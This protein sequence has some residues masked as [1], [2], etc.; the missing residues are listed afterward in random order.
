MSERKRKWDGFCPAGKHGL[1]YRGQPCDLCPAPAMPS[2]RPR[3]L[4]PHEVVIAA[5]YRACPF[6][7][8][9]DVGCRRCRICDAAALVAQ[10][11]SPPPGSRE[12]GAGRCPECQGDAADLWT[13]PEDCT[14]C[15]GRASPRCRACVHEVD[16][17][18]ER[19]A[20]EYHEPGDPECRLHAQ[21]APKTTQAPNVAAPT[22]EE[23]MATHLWFNGYDHAAGET[24]EDARRWMMQETRMSAEDCEGDGWRMVPDDEM[25]CDEAGVV[26][27]PHETAREFAESMLAAHPLRSR[28]AE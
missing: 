9:P 17:K 1:D 27:E 15:R 22:K 5:L 14:T 13:H 18:P 6:A 12:P 25:M 28:H 8:P 11:A 7:P 19:I 2:D 26:S 24:E 10:H 23:A 21:A 3:A 4:E 20:A 16:E